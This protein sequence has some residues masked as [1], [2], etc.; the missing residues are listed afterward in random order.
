MTTSELID[1]LKYLDRDGNKTVLIDT[2]G[3]GI[4]EKF[5][6][7]VPDNATWIVLEG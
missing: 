1:M 3:S 6:F 2:D 7:D 4:C 5:D